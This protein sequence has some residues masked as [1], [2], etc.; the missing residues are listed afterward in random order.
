MPLHYV[1]DAYNII[2]HIAFISIRKKIKDPHRALLELI[3][4]RRPGKKFKSNITMVFDGYPKVSVQ[5]LQEAGIDIIFSRGQTA[6]A[7]IKSLVET[8]KNPKNIVVVS[9]DREI[10]FY[11]RSVGAHILGVEEFIIA[12]EPK[13]QRRKEEQIKAELNYSQISKINHELRELW[14]N[15]KP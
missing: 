11:C 2:N 4:N 6:D 15:E 14:L 13:Q 3:K 5:N 10:Q 8:S 12:P 1:I 7:K 9:D